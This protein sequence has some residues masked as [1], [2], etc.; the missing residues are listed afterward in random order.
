MRKITTFNYRSIPINIIIN[1]LY[2]VYNLWFRYK[3]YE[4]S[5]EY[6]CLNKFER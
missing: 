2:K 5:L 6:N 3:D 1:N 4:Y